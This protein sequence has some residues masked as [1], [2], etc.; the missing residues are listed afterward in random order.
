MPKAI[1][2]IR[3]LIFSTKIEHAAR[4][5]GVKATTISHPDALAG[6]LDEGDVRLVMVDMNTGSEPAGAA[7]RQAADHA[8]K[9]ATLA[10][11]SHVQTDLRDAAAEAGADMI[12]PRSKFNAQM[13]QIIAEHCAP[14]G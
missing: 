14:D 6:L 8:S 1:A 11:Y 9:P 12:M 13:A 3:D 4:S 2:L 10:F 7:L 5:A